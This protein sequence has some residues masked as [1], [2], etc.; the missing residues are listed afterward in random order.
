MD[1]TKITFDFPINTSLQVGD[2]IYF[3]EPNADE[4]DPTLGDPVLAGKVHRIEND[5]IVIDRDPNIDP[6]PSAILN[7]PFILFA[8][9]ININESSLKGYYA[10]VTFENASNKKCELFALGS[11]IGL[12]SK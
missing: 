2:Y 4:N 11:E 7:P 1:H 5:Y 3:S 9:N 6:I 10:D 8:K 12:S